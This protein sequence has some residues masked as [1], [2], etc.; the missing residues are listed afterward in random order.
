MAAAAMMAVVAQPR[1]NVSGASV[2]RPIWS[3]R[4]P[5]HIIAAITGTATKPLMTALQN[6]ALMGSSEEKSIPI[7]R[8]VA[9][10]ITQ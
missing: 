4:L 9:A 5:T 10:T 3:L 7:P 1:V 6:S 8:M 2:K